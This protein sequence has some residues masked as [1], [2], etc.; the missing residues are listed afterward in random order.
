MA[1]TDPKDYLDRRYENAQ[2]AELPDAPIDALRG[3]GKAGSDTLRKA[4]GVK[5]IRDLADNRFVLAAQEIVRLAEG[6]TA[7]ALHHEAIS[8]VE[9]AE[10]G[11]S[12]GTQEFGVEDGGGG[13]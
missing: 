2:I 13:R 1:V 6:P 10:G 3:L 12:T 11:A 9:S 4:I 8:R 5:T 7:L